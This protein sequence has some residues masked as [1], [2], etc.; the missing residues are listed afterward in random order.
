[1]DGEGGGKRSF[2]TTLT[3]FE[4]FSSV[5]EGEGSMMRLLLP[6][7][8]VVALMWIFRGAD[9]GGLS[10]VSVLGSSS[11]VV[12]PGLGSVVVVVS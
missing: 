12:G 3:R 11:A 10:S 6:W 5:E 9:W 8:V 2:T 7:M 4:M 1:M